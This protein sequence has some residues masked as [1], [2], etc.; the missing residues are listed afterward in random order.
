MFAYVARQAIY[1]TEKRVFAYEL[2]FRDGVSNCFPDISPDE[3]TSSMLAESHLSVGVENISFNKPSF[4]NFHQDTILYRFPSTLDPLNVVIEIVE[5]VDVDSEFLKACEHIK[6]MG[7]KLALDDYDFA[8]HWDAMLPLVRYIKIESELLDLENP[9]IARK[10]QE[11]KDL[12]KILIAEKV[13]TMEEFERFK[14][15]GFEYFQGYFLSKPEVVKHKNVE[16]STTSIIELV[17]ISSAQDFDFEKTT[18]VCEKDVG[19]TY[20]LMR[21]INNPM[22]NKR[23]RIDS[24]HHA[25]RYLGAVELKKFI[26]L[27]AIANLK[28]N[29]PADLI[30]SSLA[31]AHFCKLMSQAMKLKENP[32]SSYILGLFSHMDALL[33][34]PMI[35][36]MKSLP[37]SDEVKTALCETHTDSK[38][39]LQLRICMA[40]ERADWA[41]IFELSQKADIK[42]PELFEMYYSAVK[43]ADD[44]KSILLDDKG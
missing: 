25:L 24:L 3:A 12:D 26:A 21:F 32:P 9:H 43:W 44:M 34:M 14:A 5:T 38:L 33:D 42:E 40:F 23:Q 10:I 41:V 11:L 6:N 15:A 30:V 29:K 39:A 31:R 17:G 16:V 36:I 20:K 37:F 2:L 28:G 7:Y 4:I 27:L 13:E 19:L 35:D 18:A 8:P 1:D 22:F